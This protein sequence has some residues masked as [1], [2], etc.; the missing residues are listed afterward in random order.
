[1][2]SDVKSRDS[3]F[4]GFGEK[5]SDLSQYLEK[6]ED[7]AA[8]SGNPVERLGALILQDKVWDLMRADSRGDK[9]LTFMVAS[10][11]PLKRLFP[12]L[13]CVASELPIMEN[14]ITEAFEGSRY[15]STLQHKTLDAIGAVQW[16]KIVLAWD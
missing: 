2:E 5:M 9:S 1:M 15:R 4:I 7:E 3:A 14:R 6:V 16:I 13:D 12:D 11:V 10:G 8:A